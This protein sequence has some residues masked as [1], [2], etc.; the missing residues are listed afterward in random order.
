MLFCGWL[1]HKEYRGALLL[2]QL[3]MNIMEMVYTH[4]AP[5]GK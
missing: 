4:A 3:G 1:Y 5:L 2:E